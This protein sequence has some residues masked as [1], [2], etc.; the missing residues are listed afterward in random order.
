[1]SDQRRDYGAAGCA[2]GCASRGAQLMVLV[3]LL[4]VLLR[5]KG[6]K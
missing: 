3:G 1:M 5:R 4:V 6:G 2:D